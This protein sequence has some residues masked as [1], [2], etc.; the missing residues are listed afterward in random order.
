MGRAKDKMLVDKG[1]MP[2]AETCRHL[3]IEIEE[4]KIEDEIEL[5]QRKRK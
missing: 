2:L 4:N 5:S 1:E 3:E